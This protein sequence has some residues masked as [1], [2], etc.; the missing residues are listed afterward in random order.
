MYEVHDI[1]ENKVVLQNATN[2][3]VQDYLGIT[4]NQVCRYASDG[5][6]RQKRYVV[7]QTETENE[8]KANYDVM[9]YCNDSSFAEEWRKITEYIN[10]H[11]EWCKPGTAGARTIV[12]KPTE[13]E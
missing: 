13:E 12:L 1:I 7:Y 10:K 6:I 8:R 2:K 5:C 11:V 4:S 9:Q 3:E